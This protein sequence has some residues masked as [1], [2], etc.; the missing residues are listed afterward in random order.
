MWTPC[1][2]VSS[3]LQNAVPTKIP[4]FPGRAQNSSDQ[5]RKRNSFLPED[6]FSSNFAASHRAEKVDATIDL[7]QAKLKIPDSGRDRCPL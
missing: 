2:Q 5:P 1:G 4:L 3:R 6:I 7:L